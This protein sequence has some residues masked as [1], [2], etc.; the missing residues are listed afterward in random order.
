M[1]RLDHIEYVSGPVRS[2][3]PITAVRPSDRMRFRSQSKLRP[4]KVWVRLQHSVWMDL[5]QTGL[6]SGA[7]SVDMRIAAEPVDQYSS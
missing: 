1:L 6:S 2:R 4:L 5:I 3:V 7:G